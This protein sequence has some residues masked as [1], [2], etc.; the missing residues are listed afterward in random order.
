MSEATPDIA[1]LHEAVLTGDANTAV[2]VTQAALAAGIAPEQL[3]TGQMIPAMDEV[4]RRFENNEYF[5]PELLI[6]A[7]SICLARQV[8]TNDVAESRDMPSVSVTTGTKLPAIS[9]SAM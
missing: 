2:E 4:G 1:K 9:S 6:A 8:R 5:V 7:R 3:V